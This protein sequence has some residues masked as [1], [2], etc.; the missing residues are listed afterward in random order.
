M[1]EALIP[2]HSQIR[3]CNWEIHIFHD[4]RLMKNAE[5]IYQPDLL[6]LPRLRCHYSILHYFLDQCET[7]RRQPILHLIGQKIFVSFSVKKIPFHTLLMAY[8]EG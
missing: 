2:F 8:L 3:K 6:D 4:H 7:C 5:I 1:Y